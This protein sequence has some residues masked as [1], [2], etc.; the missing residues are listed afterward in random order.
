MFSV[1]LR[2]CGL[3]FLSEFHLCTAFDVLI[4]PTL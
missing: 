1:P 3:L 4:L 2:L